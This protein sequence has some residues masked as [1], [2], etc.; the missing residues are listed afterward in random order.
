MCYFRLEYFKSEQ[1]G[2]IYKPRRG[3]GPKTK[4][5]GLPEKE[6]KVNHDIFLSCILSVKDTDSVFDQHTGNFITEMGG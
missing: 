3:G 2:S 4:E 6:L 1:F 5:T